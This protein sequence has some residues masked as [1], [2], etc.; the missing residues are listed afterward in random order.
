MGPLHKGSI[1]RPIA[2]RANALTTELHLAPEIAQWVHSIKDRS[3]DPSHDERTLLPWS[4][5]SLHWSKTEED[6]TETNRRTYPLGRDDGVD[7]PDDDPYVGDGCDDPADR[8]PHGGERVVCGDVFVV[9]GQVL[10]LEE[11]EEPETLETT[12]KH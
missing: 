8:L 7:G 1:R 4:Y 9:D 3:D 10:H 2:P 11:H 5:I 12:K 6:E